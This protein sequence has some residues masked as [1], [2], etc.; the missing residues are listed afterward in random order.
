MAVGPAQRGVEVRG[1]SVAISS[2]QCRQVAGG[3]ERAI[4]L[5][6][7]VTGHQMLEQVAERSLGVKLEQE[8]V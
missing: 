5:D 6:P 8:V 3:P 4:D 2:S 1:S 7:K